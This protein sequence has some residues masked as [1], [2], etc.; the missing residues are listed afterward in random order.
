MRTQLNRIYRNI[1][2]Q[3]YNLE[4]KM[5]QNVLAMATQLPDIFAYY[6]MKFPGYTLILAGRN[7][8]HN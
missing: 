6:L 3:Q 4:Q 1:L 7:N 5:L 8:T 2:Y